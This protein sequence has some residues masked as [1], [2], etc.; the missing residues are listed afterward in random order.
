MMTIFG[1]NSSTAEFECKSCGRTITVTKDQTERGEQIECSCGENY[2]LSST[3]SVFEYGK[4][5]SI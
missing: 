1:S 3:G 5:G 4:R 2:G